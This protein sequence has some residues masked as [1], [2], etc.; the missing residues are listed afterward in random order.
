MERMAKP[1]TAHPFLVN[2]EWNS[3]GYFV[4]FTLL[5]FLDLRYRKEKG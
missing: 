3:L 4:F 1:G 2:H 5:G